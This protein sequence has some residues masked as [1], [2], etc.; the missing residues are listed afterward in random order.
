M[1]YLVIGSGVCGVQAAETIRRHDPD[2]PITLIGGETF[3]PYCRPMITLVLGGKIRPEQM[4]IR[5]QN[6]FTSFRIHPV[7][8]EWVEQIDLENRQ[9]LTD[10]G[11]SYSFDRLLIATGANPKRIEL[12]GADLKNV[13][14]LRSEAHVESIVHSLASAKTALVLGCGL[15]GLKAALELLH[16]GLQV[17]VVEKLSHPL[18]VI[19][20]EKAGKMIFRQLEK[21]G[22]KVITGVEIG[23]LGG[24][25]EVKE[26]LLSDGSRIACDVLIS[27]VGVQPATELV[28]AGS[29]RVN[30]GILV[31]QYLETTVPGIYAAGDVAE[32][33]D[34]AHGERRVNAIWPVAVEQG[35][36][37]GMNIAGREVLY[38][39]S[40]GRNVFRIDGMDI[41]AGGIVNPSR[42][43]NYEICSAEDYRRGTYRMLVF[44]DEIPVGFLMVND[45]EQAGVFLSLIQRKISVNHHKDRLLDPSFNFKQLLPSR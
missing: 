1:K 22:I 10:K 45:I 29:I 2:S 3:L 18:P 26:A 37:A 11:R 15:V 27:A 13:F 20:D 36:V 43:K 34:V 28:P 24:K 42:S 7:A 32:S 39:G 38:Q 8:G 5:D 35:V 40:V 12:E 21:M 14:H 30:D 17:T 19:V 6:F 9:V 16:R 25:A 4:I 41:V 44:R 23:A 33:Y 31:N